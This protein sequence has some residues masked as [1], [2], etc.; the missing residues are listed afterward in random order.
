L[1]WVCVQGLGTMLQSSE[2]PCLTWRA[3]T[4]AST[5]SEWE[6]DSQS[7]AVS[8]ESFD[9]C[10]S[11]TCR[12]QTLFQG[13]SPNPNSASINPG[14]IPRTLHFQDP[15][16]HDLQE[17]DSHHNH[18]EVLEESAVHTSTIR[19]S[20]TSVTD[21]GAAQVQ[22]HNGQP[23]C[24]NM[25][26]V[27]FSDGLSNDLLLSEA[28]LG[29]NDVAGESFDCDPTALLACMT[30][31]LP[32]ATL[33]DAPTNFQEMELLAS[34]CHLGPS[35]TSKPLSPPHGVEDSLYSETVLL[36]PGRFQGGQA[37]Q[38]DALGCDSVQH[39]AALVE[40]ETSTP[41]VNSRNYATTL[42]AG[43]RAVSSFVDPL[44]VFEGKRSPVALVGVSG[45]TAFSRGKHQIED[46]VRTSMSGRSRV[47]MALAALSSCLPSHLQSAGSDTI[48]D[49]APLGSNPA[50]L[51]TFPP[52]WGLPHAGSH[53]QDA[54]LS[55]CDVPC[56]EPSAAMGR[57]A[58]QAPTHVCAPPTLN[59]G[60]SQDIA[61]IASVGGESDIN[62]AH[63]MPVPSSL[64]D[65]ALVFAARTARRLHEVSFPLLEI[66][67]Y[68]VLP[69][70]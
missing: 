23:E 54:V 34:P 64:D 66:Q 16:G 46:P 68:D 44:R 56:A 45:M 36:A 60:L 40:D 41:C 70:S 39:L 24:A 25:L 50:L 38:E 1:G 43:C 13:P 3:L 32:P 61:L 10:N 51:E 53:S 65:L 57:G 5:P 11:P 58:G 18:N 29:S 15:F 52:D 9:D 69:A 49:T 42:P 47:S 35:L 17:I 12:P 4:D 31:D 28:G 37:L 8:P 30:G 20:F 19:L 59:C 55:Q 14:P 26:K 6:T 22:A 63:T 33:A 21:Q 48:P 2:N 62:P 7:S 67:M 27:P